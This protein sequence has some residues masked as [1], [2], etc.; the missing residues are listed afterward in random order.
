MMADDVP[1][2]V[3]GLT[4]GADPIVGS[5]LTLAGLENLDVKGF[6]VRKEAKGHGTRSRIEGPVADGSRVI[7]IE[8]VVTTGGSS[9]KA[10]E[11]IR[12]IDCKVKRV[13]AL[14]DREQG[15]KDNLKEVG[16]RLE[17]IF[18]IGELLNPRLAL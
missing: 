2:A 5:I 4:L 7:I 6:I 15:G 18:S 12:E 11:A 9:M 1:D 16:C 13:F 14:V 10:I 17:S 3:G 8:D